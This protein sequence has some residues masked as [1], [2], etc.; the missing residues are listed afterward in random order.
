M[1]LKALFDRVVEFIADQ[2]PAV[3]VVLHD[4]DG[5]T[6]FLT[7]DGHTLDHKP[8]MRTGQRL[9][10]FHSVGSLAAWLN[11]H[12]DPS[13]TDVLVNTNGLRVDALLDPRDAN[14]EHVTAR[15]LLHP[16]LRHW[17]GK[18]NMMLSQNQ[19]YEVL[20]AGREDTAL[21]TDS[22]G[23]LLDGHFYGDELA[24]Q[25]L[26]M[27]AVKSTDI[28]VR[29]NEMGTMIWSGRNDTVRVD[30]K[31]PSHFSI[32][33]PFF[34]EM[35]EEFQYHL[36]LELRMTVIEKSDPQFKLSCPEIAMRLLE[37]SN[38][39]VENFFK[40]A[41]DDAFL[42][43]VGSLDHRVVDGRVDA[44]IGDPGPVEPHR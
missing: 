43:S 37:A 41:L 17:H 26:Q 36:R 9:H 8:T 24:R 35:G 28:D 23:K 39:L 5:K 4:V 21:T 2:R 42:V 7:R 3:E 31:L 22:A 1:D 34:E 16:R 6:W 30:G 25:L 38:D 33:V 14:G 20:L 40:P 18:F 13:K 44:P 32:E 27:R 19:L 11:R 10:E 12:A 15:M 29:Y